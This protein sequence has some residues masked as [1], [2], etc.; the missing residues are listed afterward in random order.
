MNDQRNERGEMITVAT[1]YTNTNRSGYEYLAGNWGM[2]RVFV[3]ETHPNRRRPDGPTH[4]LVFGERQ[5]R[6]T[7]QQV[8]TGDAP[9]RPVS[10]DDIPF[11][12]ALAVLGLSLWGMCPA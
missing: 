10:D 4:R 8:E 1:L 5:E 6:A 12:W 3:F 2:A 7:D 9:A 11:M